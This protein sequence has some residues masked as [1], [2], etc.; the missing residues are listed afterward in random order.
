[1]EEALPLFKADPRAAQVQHVWEERSAALAAAGV[2]SGDAAAAFAASEQLRL[3]CTLAD[4]PSSVLG[5]VSE[6]FADSA[7]AHSQARSADEQVFMDAMHLRCG[8]CD[9]GFACRSQTSHWPS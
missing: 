8:F 2:K 9:T 1:M 5:V 3:P 4:T 7:L 6:A